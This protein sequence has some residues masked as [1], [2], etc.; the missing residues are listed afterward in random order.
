MKNGLTDFWTTFNINDIYTIILNDFQALIDSKNYNEIL[1]VFNNKGLIHNSK[2][3][4]LCDLSTKNDSY[5]N[6]IIGILKLNNEKSVR[7]KQAVIGK[8]KK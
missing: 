6:F 3:V 8:I 7:I 2:V 4:N 1:K 5:L